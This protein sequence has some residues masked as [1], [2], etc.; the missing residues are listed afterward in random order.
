MEC[1]DKFQTAYDAVRWMCLTGQWQIKSD[2]FLF[3]FAVNVRFQCIPIIDSRLLVEPAGQ[4]VCTNRTH[5]ISTI[6]CRTRKYSTTCSSVSIFS[7]VSDTSDRIF[8][9][10]C[11]R[12]VI[13]SW[14]LLIFSISMS[15]DSL[16]LRQ[17]TNDDCKRDGSLTSLL[18][19]T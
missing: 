13:F 5:V 3:I 11:N 18:M 7:T 9:W 6:S 12:S 2:N 16:T 14:Y 10:C 17:W 8:W 15:I 4:H 19:V 1:F